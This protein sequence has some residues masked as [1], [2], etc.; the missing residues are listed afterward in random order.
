V[1]L[2]VSI[3]VT[4]VDK[5]GCLPNGRIEAMNLFIRRPGAPI[6]WVARRRMKKAQSEGGF[7]GSQ[8]AGGDDASGEAGSGIGTITGRS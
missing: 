3:S 6:T 4:V 8:T 7:A 2:T 5:C 1:N